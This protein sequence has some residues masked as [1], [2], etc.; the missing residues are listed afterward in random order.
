MS[1][2]SE[3]LSFQS[4]RVMWTSSFIPAVESSGERRLKIV[5]LWLKERTCCKFVP[6]RVFYFDEPCGTAIRL[7]TSCIIIYI[8]AY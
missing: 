5:L 7:L 2:D 8:D 3:L 1:E 6:V 4:C